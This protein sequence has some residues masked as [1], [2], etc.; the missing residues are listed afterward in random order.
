LERN[1]GAEGAGGGADGRYDLS[2]NACIQ[3]RAQS[4]GP[5]AVEHHSAVVHFTT[6]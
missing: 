3:T 2:A 1:P 6:F 5:Q 4:F